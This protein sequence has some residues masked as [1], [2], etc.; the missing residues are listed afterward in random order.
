M[1]NTGQKLYELLT[2]LNSGASLPISLATVLVD[3][4]KTIIEEE[5]PWMALRKTDSTKTV[6]PSSTWQTAIDL[7]TITDFS[8][9]YVNQDGV[10]LR[11]F[12]GNNRIHYYTLK[13]FDQRL[14]YKD[15]GDTCVFDENTKSLYLNG[16][17]PFSGTLHIPY[18][19]TSSEVDLESESAVWT[20]FPQRFTTLLGYYAIA[21]HM[22]AVDFDTV[23]ARMAPNQLEIM[24]A[25]KNAMVSWDNEKQLA[26][27]QSNDP[28]TIMGYPRLG[29]VNMYE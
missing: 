24:R 17:V 19:A 27:L 18:M 5:R 28:T 10:V 22:G 8:R 15:F 16:L 21:V 11:L 9:F 20:V 1:I 3:T 7:S 2:E 26:S 25:L 4:A 6:T 14:E 12:D 13:P 23:T 29:T